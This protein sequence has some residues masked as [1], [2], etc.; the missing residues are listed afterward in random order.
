MMLLHFIPLVPVVMVLLVL[1][2]Y[3]FVMRKRRGS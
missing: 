2:L 3:L 1:V